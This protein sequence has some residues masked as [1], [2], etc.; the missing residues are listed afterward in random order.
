M[1]LMLGSTRAVSL[2]CCLAGAEA[3]EQVLA[4]EPVM[5]LANHAPFLAG[6]VHKAAYKEGAAP[7]PPPPPPDCWSPGLLRCDA[8]AL[9]A[10]S[11]P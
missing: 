11:S 2:M 1:T 6:K 10:S 8:S 7:G 9:P 3:G 4:L 5:D